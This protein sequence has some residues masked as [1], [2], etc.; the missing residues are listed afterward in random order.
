MKNLLSTVIVLLFTCF[1]LVNF[2]VLGMVESSLNATAIPGTYL[3][4]YGFWLLL[5]VAYYLL[6][7]KI[8][9]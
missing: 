4:F 9:E 5:I 7:R 8:R 1:L 6:F 3:Y 2:P